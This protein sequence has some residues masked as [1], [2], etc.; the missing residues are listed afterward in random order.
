M[1]ITNGNLKSHSINIFHNQ[2]K[3]IDEEMMSTMNNIIIQMNMLQVQVDNLKSQRKSL[4]TQE[5]IQSSFPYEEVIHE[6]FTP[7]EGGDE[8]ESKDEDDDDD[9]KVDDK[10]QMKTLNWEESVELQ[11]NGD[12]EK[13]KDGSIE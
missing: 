9:E 10:I 7:S 5:P 12:I 8:E 2:V 4:A 11:A 13:L 3:H 1:A 6:L